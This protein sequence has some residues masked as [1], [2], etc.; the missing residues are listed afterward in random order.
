MQAGV[1]RDDTE[2]M[3]CEARASKQMRYAD[4]HLSLIGCFASVEILSLPPSRSSDV[5]PHQIISDP[6]SFLPLADLTYLPVQIN[7]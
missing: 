7:H 1:R 2:A 3:P 5:R 6:Q 4:L